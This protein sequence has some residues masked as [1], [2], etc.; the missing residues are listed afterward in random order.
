MNDTTKEYNVKNTQ[1]NKVCHTLRLE[2]SWNLVT[3]SSRV[4]VRVCVCVCLCVSRGGGK[5]GRGVGERGEKQKQYFPGSCPI[6]EVFV[7]ETLPHWPS[8][9][10]GNERLQKFL[11]AMMRQLLLH[12]ILLIYF[13]ARIFHFFFHQIKASTQLLI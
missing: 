9:Q 5:V 7:R 4:C 8:I 12:S 13:T 2:G 1:T 10:I 11:H 3:L 6:W